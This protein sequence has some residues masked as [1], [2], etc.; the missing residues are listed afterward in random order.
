LVGVGVGVLVFDGRG[1]PSIN[2]LW[3]NLTTS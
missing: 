3:E 1:K 2:P